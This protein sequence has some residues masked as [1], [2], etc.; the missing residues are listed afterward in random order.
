MDKRFKTLSIKL[1]DELTDLTQLFF[2]KNLRQTEKTS[3][4][5]N[6]AMSA[7]LSSLF[8]CMRDI[9][10]NNKQISIVVKEFIAKISNDLA[11]TYPISS[12]ETE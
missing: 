5:I 4:M 11:N 12:I 10:K 3:D 8:N 2:L 7:H 6:L 1:T 9:A